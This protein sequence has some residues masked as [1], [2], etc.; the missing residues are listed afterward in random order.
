MTL[1]PEQSSFGS[2]KL[3]S[4]IIIGLFLTSLAQAS[5][6]APAS[7]NGVVRTGV[8]LNQILSSSDET[9]PYSKCSREGNGLLM[10]SNSCKELID[11]LQRKLALMTLESDI[12]LQSEKLNPTENRK[13]KQERMGMLTK[14]NL[15]STQA[16]DSIKSLKANYPETRYREHLN[17]IIPEVKKVQ[18]SLEAY[19][20]TIPH[21]NL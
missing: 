7:R 11:Q 6:P 10:F 16:E 14:L 2:V 19:L 3:G 12:Q 8:I 18:T 4:W 15:L 5:I 20:R 13:R 9:S 21:G 17:E 1:P